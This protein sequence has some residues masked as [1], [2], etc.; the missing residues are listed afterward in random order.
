MRNSK[1]NLWNKVGTP[2]YSPGR[3][4][5]KLNR[6]I[7]K[8]LPKIFVFSNIPYVFSY[9][10]NIGKHIY[11]Q[12]CYEIIG[13]SQFQNSSKIFPNV[14]CKNSLQT[15]LERNKRVYTKLLHM[16]HITKR[17]NARLCC[18]AYISTENDHLLAFVFN[19]SLLEGLHNVQVE[20]HLKVQ[21]VWSSSTNFP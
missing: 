9:I 12:N 3:N 18:N 20:S 1:R 13:F 14:L 7:W 21:H 6:R 15:I 17:E 2:G 16:L 5:T 19:G 11:D 10:S 4:A 8:R